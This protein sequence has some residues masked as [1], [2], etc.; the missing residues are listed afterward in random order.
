[1][2]VEKNG[3]KERVQNYCKFHATEGHEIQ[4]YADFKALVQTLMDNKDLEYFAK[5]EG[6]DGVDICTF[7][8]ETSEKTYK[9]NH[10]PRGSEVREKV[11]QRIIIQNLV[12]FPYKDSKRVPWSYDCNVMVQGGESSKV[13]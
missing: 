7:G 2:G 9:I 12:T 4:S 8:E 13:D 3:V 11:V 5:I 1:M 6:L 10:Q